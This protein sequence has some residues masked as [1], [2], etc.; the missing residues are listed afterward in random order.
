MSSRQTHLAAFKHR[1]HLR[2]S[3][4]AGSRQLPGS[5][6]QTA[7]AD[8]QTASHISAGHR[9][10]R[11]AYCVLGPAER[12]ETQRF[13]KAVTRYLCGTASWSHT[14]R[15]A[16]SGA[17]GS[18]G[19]SEEDRGRANPLLHCD[20]GLQSYNVMLYP[21]PLPGSQL[22]RVQMATLNCQNNPKRRSQRSRRLD[23][24][25]RIEIP[26]KWAQV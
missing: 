5:R 17:Q 21:R 25:E 7:A 26:Y 16:A 3:R 4:R 18:R 11:C 14:V 13:C 2:L 8:S 15:T 12:A 22:Q 23:G 24:A 6:Q 10:F 20:S 9:P 19:N 1:I